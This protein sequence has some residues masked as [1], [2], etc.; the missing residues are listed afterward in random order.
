MYHDRPKQ[1]LV[2]F[3]ENTMIPKTDLSSVIATVIAYHMHSRD[4][5]SAFTQYTATASVQ[6][7]S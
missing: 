1:K 6:R 3:K 7:H 2:G 5:I 4:L